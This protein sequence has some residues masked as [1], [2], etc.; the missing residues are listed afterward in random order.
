MKSYVPLAL[1]VTA[2]MPA[3]AQE[4]FDGP[5]IGLQAGFG[6]HEIDTVR[7]D[8]GDF[9]APE[10]SDSLSV[11]VFLGYDH[12]VASWLVLGGEVGVS[13]AE[14]E[15]TRRTARGATYT[16]DVK[17]SLDASLRAG[18]PITST[19]LLFARGGYANVRVGTELRGA[20]TSGRGSATLDGWLVGGGFEQRLLGNVSG[21]LEYRYSEFDG[22]N[23]GYQR[24]ELLL[25][26]AYR[27]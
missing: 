15:E 5:S 21:R 7:T 18:I 10:A 6:N 9:D 13:I 11:G 22:S 17:R 24:H 19:G 4:S 25:G 8:I 26:A 2:A 1:A 14:G 16:I 3:A 23:T 20:E 12:Q 27:F